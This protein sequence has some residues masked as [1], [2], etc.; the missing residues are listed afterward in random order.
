MG[1]KERSLGR[2]KRIVGNRA[3]NFKEAE[4]W[5][6]ECWQN[7]TPEQRLSALVAIHRDASKVEKGRQETRSRQKNRK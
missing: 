7:Q 1:I 6:L 3:A 5:D 4:D 2:R